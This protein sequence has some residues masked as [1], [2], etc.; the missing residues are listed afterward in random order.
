MLENG[1]LESSPKE[2]VGLHEV[3]LLAMGGAGTRNQGLLPSPVLLP[4][5]HCDSGRF[6]KRN[7]VEGRA[8][9]RLT[10]TLRISLTKLHL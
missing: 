2:A 9:V 1:Q 8:N 6:K 3:T 10:C 5:H 4:Q 7:R